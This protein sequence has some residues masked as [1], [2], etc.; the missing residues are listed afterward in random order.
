MNYLFQRHVT[1]GVP[2]S[3]ASLDAAV[4]LVADHLA[5]LRRTAGTDVTGGRFF[6]F[7][8]GWDL[9]IPQLL[10]CFGVHEQVVVDIRP[11]VRPTLVRDVARRLAGRP[12]HPDMVRV[13]PDPGDAGVD[14]HLQRLGID[15]RAPCDARATG[16]PPGSVDVI[17]STNTLEHI[18]PADIVDILR[19]CDRILSPDGWMSFQI[20]YRDHF[21][22]FDGRLSIYNFLRFDEDAWRRYSPA[23]HFQNR[24]RHA[25]HLALIR[26]A[27]FEVADEVATRG[28]PDQEAALAA[29]PLGAPFRDRP[30]EELAVCEGRLVLRR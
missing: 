23:L 26:Q 8:A 15:Y 18:P 1:H 27:G 17:T 14:V 25:D 6:E 24:L 12:R 28:G 19:E 9:H 20:D 22:Y 3:D 16:L 11:L 5:R 7:G 4:D 30:F 29:L 10:W 2:I 21:S 13:P